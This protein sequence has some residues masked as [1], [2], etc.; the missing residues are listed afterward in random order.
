M[1]M[2]TF[3]Y[4]FTKLNTALIIA[5][6]ALCVVGFTI[7]LVQCIKYGT[8]SAADPVYPIIQYTIMFIVTVVLGSLLVS[9]LLFSE[10]VVDGKYFKTRFGFIV[11]KYDTEKIEVVTLD[12]KTNKLVVT[13]TDNNYIV[14]VVK[15]EWYEEFVTALLGANP[16]IEYR[17]RSED[18]KDE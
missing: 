6:I 16:K 9:V 2:K 15:E 11:S 8:A 7:N 13:F 10:Y 1:G 14:I 12:R 5:G 3:K 18:E 4:K 17:I